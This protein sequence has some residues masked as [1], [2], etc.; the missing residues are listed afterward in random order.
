MPVSVFACVRTWAYGYVPE[1][2]C[3]SVFFLSERVYIYRHACFR[4]SLCVKEI[5]CIPMNVWACERTRAYM[6]VRDCACV[7]VSVNVCACMYICVMACL[8]AFTCT[9]RA[10]VCLAFLCVLV[11]VPV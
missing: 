5:V 7:S 11:C 8:L 2:M 1:C 10:Q 9:E 4:V 6:F 3:A